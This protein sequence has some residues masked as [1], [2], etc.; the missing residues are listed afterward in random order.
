MGQ[1]PG[2]KKGKNVGMAIVAYIIF[3]IPL[4]TDAKNDPFVKYHVKQGLVIFILG[5]ITAII[6]NI[7]IISFF[8][9]LINLAL[10]VLVILGI[11]NAANGK[12][13]PL[14]VVGHFAD[15]FKF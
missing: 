3:F 13:E 6:G 5:V 10:L 11:V 4:L 12:E 15:K 1:R 9:W 7:P 14:P 8:A 2:D